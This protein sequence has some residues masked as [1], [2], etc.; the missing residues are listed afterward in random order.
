MN[1][2]YPASIENEAVA[3]LRGREGRTL[4]GAQILSIS[5]SFWENMAKLYVGAPS[6]GKSWIC[7]YEVLTLATEGIIYFALPFKSTF[8]CIVLFYSKLR[9]IFLIVNF[10]AASDRIFE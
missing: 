1:A 7:H 4:P 5:C 6:S 2:L 3:D 9:L 8:N 10:T